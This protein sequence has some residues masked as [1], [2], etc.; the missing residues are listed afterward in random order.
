MDLMSCPETLANNYQPTL[1]NIPEEWR[2][3][4]HCNGNLM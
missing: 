4:L 2:S 3:L 1:Y